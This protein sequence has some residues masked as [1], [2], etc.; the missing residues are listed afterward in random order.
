MAVSQKIWLMTKRNSGFDG[1]LAVSNALY[2]E[3]W[4]S[5]IHVIYYADWRIKLGLFNV[6]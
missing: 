6:S 1:G 2:F 3:M 4:L 5:R